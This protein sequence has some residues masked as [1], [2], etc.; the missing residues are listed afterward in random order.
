MILYE[1]YIIL[2]ILEHIQLQ[3]ITVGLNGKN[4]KYFQLVLQLTRNPKLLTRNC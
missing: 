1:K 2:D 4:L 3:L